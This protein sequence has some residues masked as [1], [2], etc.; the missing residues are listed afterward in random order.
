MPL[1][2]KTLITID[3]SISARWIKSHN[4]TSR[5]NAR[6]KGDSDKMCDG[7]LA[8]KDSSLLFFFC[9]TFTYLTAKQ[10]TRHSS[11]IGAIYRPPIGL[12]K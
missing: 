1:R 5:L 8:H 6:R 12:V 10:L 7:F 4:K 11:D 9:L 2:Y 3:I